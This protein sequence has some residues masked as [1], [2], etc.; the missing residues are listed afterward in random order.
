MGEAGVRAILDIAK[1][2]IEAQKLLKSSGAP[3]V[4]DFHNKSN[5]GVANQD[6]KV[7]G[8]GVPVR[9]DNPNLIDWEKVDPEKLDAVTKE[10]RD[11]QIAKK[12]RLGF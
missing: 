7:N 2:K 9:A 12:K 3:A 11:R 4:D 1:A 8:R 6:V 5:L 10:F